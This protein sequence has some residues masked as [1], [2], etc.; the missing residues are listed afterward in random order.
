[1]KH[2]KIR[3][4]FIKQTAAFGVC[5]SILSAFAQVQIPIRLIVGSAAGGP[6]D[7]AA[8]IVSEQV[9]LKL[10][11]SILVENKPGAS[12]RIANGE[13]KRAAP[14]GL[15]LL[16]SPLG[17][18]TVLPN[19]Y[20]SKNLG[21]VPEDFTPVARVVGIE[22]VLAASTNSKIINLA[23]L[24]E[25]LTRNPDRASIA[26]PGTGTIPNL[27]AILLAK[28]TG[29]PLQHVSYKGS[30]PAMSDLMGDHVSLM[31]GTPAEMINHHKAGKLRIIGTFSEKRSPV[32][33]DVQTLKEQGV[34]V[35]I[36][37]A[38]GVWAPAGT[39]PAIVENISSA[40]RVAIGNATVMADLAKLGFTATPSSPAELAKIQQED[41]KR[42]SAFIKIAGIEMTE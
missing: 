33:P 8:R 35:A 17:A 1:M 14:D 22:F 38:F 3:R 12:T 41:L 9:K 10:N 30:A 19:L 13:V 18:M 26:N 23:Q 16:F 7:I 34:A 20:S 28:Q 39:P 31:I 37:D 11:R 27:L 40:F 4:N 24:K 5:I 15:T 36:E 2:L 6:T 32:L 25:F 21:Y 42:W 29:V